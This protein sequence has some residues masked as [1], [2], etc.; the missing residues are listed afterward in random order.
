MLSMYKRTFFGKLVKVENKSL[1]DIF[2]RELVA[3]GALVVVIIGLGIYPKIILA[4]LNPTLNQLIN[5]MEIKA[6]N[7]E[8]KTRLKVSNSI[9]ENK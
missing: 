9:G 2:G 5:V 1:K 8:S 4:P 7:E 6:V 3:L